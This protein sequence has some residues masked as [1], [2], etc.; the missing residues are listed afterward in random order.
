VSAA[1]LPTGIQVF[2]RSNRVSK[3]V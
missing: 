1:L 2:S 3:K